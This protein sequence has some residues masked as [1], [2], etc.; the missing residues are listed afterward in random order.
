VVAYS[1]LCAAVCIFSIASGHLI[2]LE[3]P[4]RWERIYAKRND[5]FFALGVLGVVGVMKAMMQRGGV[6]TVVCGSVLLRLA[7]LELMGDEN[8]GD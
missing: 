5:P 3:P 1:N 7:V 8:R 6:D 2:Q 4:N